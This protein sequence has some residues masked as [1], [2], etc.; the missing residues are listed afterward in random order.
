VRS[1]PKRV[2]ELHNKCG[3][4]TRYWFVCLTHTHNR[5]I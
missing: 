2:T 3:G 1:M 4:Y 5:Y